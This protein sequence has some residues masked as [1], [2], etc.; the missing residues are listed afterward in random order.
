MKPILFD[1]FLKVNIC[2][3][4]QTSTDMYQTHALASPCVIALYCFTLITKQKNQLNKVTKGAEVLIRSE[5]SLLTDLH[6]L[7]L[8]PRLKKLNLTN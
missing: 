7:S 5:I 6:K 4:Y 1:I 2:N 8:F 3:D